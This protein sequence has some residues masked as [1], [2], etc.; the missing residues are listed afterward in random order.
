ML[1]FRRR[2]PSQSDMEQ[3]SE[4]HDVGAWGNP[5]FENRE[6]WGSLCRG[7]AEAG[8]GASIQCSGR[9]RVRAPAPIACPERSRRVSQKRRDL[10]HPDVEVST[11]SKSLEAYSR[12]LPPF[13]KDAK[14]GAPCF[15]S[16]ILSDLSCRFVCRQSQGQRQRARVP[17]PHLQSFHTLQ[18]LHTCKVTTLAKVRRRGRVARVHTGFSTSFFR[19]QLSGGLGR[20]SIPFWCGRLGC[21]S[22]GLGL[23]LRWCGTWRR[24]CGW[25]VCRRWCTGCGCRGLWCGRC[26]PLR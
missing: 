25:S 14:D 21:G 6:R 24:G 10:G 5:P 11:E 15:F 26:R 4:S 2:E 18:N 7:G 9:G 19:Q 16:K 13:A 23:L 17:A 1:C 12:G 22:R 3:E 8:K 20:G